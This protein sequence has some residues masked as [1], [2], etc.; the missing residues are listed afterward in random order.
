M[1]SNKYPMILLI[2][3]SAF[4]VWSGISPHDTRLTWVLE[5][6]P[7]MIALPVML[8]LFQEDIGRQKRKRLNTALDTLHEKH[9]YKSVCPGALISSSDIIDKKGRRL[10]SKHR[11]DL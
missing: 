7:V 3:V 8:C 2:I 6:F 11:E 5:T 9:G 10:T 1:S 4:W